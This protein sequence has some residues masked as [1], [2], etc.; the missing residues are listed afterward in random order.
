VE[1]HAGFWLK[2]WLAFRIILV[3]AKQPGR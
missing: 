2:T 1:Y 3:G